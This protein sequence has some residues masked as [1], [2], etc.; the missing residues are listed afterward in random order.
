ML[1]KLTAE[2]IE[3]ARGLLDEG[4]PPRDVAKASATGNIP[5]DHEG[6]GEVA[7]AE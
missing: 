1:S 5:T 3:M 4:K 6:T 7:E 2:Q